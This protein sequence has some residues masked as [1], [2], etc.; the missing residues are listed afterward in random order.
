MLV[1]YKERNTQI[2]LR[3]YLF[4]NLPYKELNQE[5]ITS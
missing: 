5:C 2:G 1:H 3:D 4:Y